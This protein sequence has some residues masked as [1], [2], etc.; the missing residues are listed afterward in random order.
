[1]SLLTPLKMIGFMAAGLAL[2][3][4]WKVGSYIVD[5]VKNDEDIN[6]FAESLK[7]SYKAWVFEE[8]G[9][10]LWKR[11]FGPLS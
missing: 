5:T 11:K 4:G 7:D 8:R 3:I 9:E 1:M 10:P 6:N 2:G